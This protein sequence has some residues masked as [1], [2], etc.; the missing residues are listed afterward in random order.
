MDTTPVVY[1]YSITFMNGKKELYPISEFKKLEDYI[2][3]N[4]IDIIKN[5]IF[6]FWIKEK[7]ELFP[8]GVHN[9]TLAK[10]L[11]NNNFFVLFYHYYD[12]HNNNIL[13]PPEQQWYDY[14]AIIDLF[15]T[16][17]YLPLYI[18]PLIIYP[19]T[20]IPPSLQRNDKLA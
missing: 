1:Q 7:S 9:I 5:I 18:L 15:K 10:N 17:L 3:F 20:I 8:Y 16:K 6:D 12:W 14:H 4:G 19:F 2:V 11:T 13:I